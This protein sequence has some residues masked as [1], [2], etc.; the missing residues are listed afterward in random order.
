MQTMRSGK[1]FEIRVGYLKECS[2]AA[3]LTV[4][5]HRYNYEPPIVDIRAC[6]FCG[7][8]YKKRVYLSWLMR[9]SAQEL[10]RFAQ[11]YLT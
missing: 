2:G 10:H 3:E 8:V 6:T 4:R 1:T 11:R 9:V 7:E 5:V